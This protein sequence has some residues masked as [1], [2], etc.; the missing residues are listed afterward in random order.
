MTSLF[1]LDGDGATTHVR[2]E[3]IS[4]A[5]NLMRVLSEQETFGPPAETAWALSGAYLFAKRL[6]AARAPKVNDAKLEDER[7]G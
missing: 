1:E 4:P 7:Q 5:D 2:G 3:T 6:Q